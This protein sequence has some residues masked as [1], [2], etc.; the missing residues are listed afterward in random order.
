MKKIFSI[1]AAVIL[2]FVVVLLSVMAGV[3]KNIGFDI[4]K[5][6]WINVYY[7]ST[8][9]TNDGA[10]YEETDEEYNEI[11]EQLKK[12]TTLSLLN[13]TLK[14]GSLNYE[15]EYDTKFYATY[16]SSMKN[17][18]LV[19]ELI[20]QSQKELVVYDNESARTIPYMCLQFIIPTDGNFEEI[21]VYSSLSNNASSKEDQ[22]KTCTPF[23]LK[24][25][26][27]KII[28]YANTLV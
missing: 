9:T 16:D 19:I 20:Y 6:T 2:V 21:V 23:I 17:E 11:L 4:E 13:L 5:P 22:Y 15:I 10:S 1:V 7:K 14:N 24:G 8:T 26:V 25:Q 28:K 3:K 27:K 18:N 12:M